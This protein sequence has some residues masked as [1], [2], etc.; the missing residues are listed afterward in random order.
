MKI[1]PSSLAVLPALALVQTAHAE[2]SNTAS[3]SGTVQAQVVDPTLIALVDDLRFGTMLK[4]GTGGTLT[5]G[6][7]GSVNTTGG[8]SG[9][10]AIPQPAD[11]RGPAAFNVE[12]DGSLVLIVQVPTF[13]SISNGSSS[14]RVDQFRTNTFFGSGLFNAQ[15]EYDLNVGGRL[16]VNANQESGTYTG[17]FDVTVL[18]L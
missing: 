2:P 17:K 18:Y 6:T 10:I 15:G 1:R 5:I 11:G 14:M 13:V 4:P 12:G 3:V 7:N 16:N 9:N 8:V